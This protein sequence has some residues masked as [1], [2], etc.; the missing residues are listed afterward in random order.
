MCSACNSTSL[1]K[2][3]LE[4]L[5]GLRA[6]RWLK[7]LG[8]DG[9]RNKSSHHQD[10]RNQG[11]PAEPLLLTFTHNLLTLDDCDAR[12]FRLPDKVGVNN[13]IEPGKSLD[14]DTR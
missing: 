8:N 4:V 1:W 11:D 13:E 12:L 5:N 14:R 3:S 6:Q 9:C 10:Q 7:V 2:R